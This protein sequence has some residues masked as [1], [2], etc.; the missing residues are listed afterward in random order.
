MS[1]QENQHL[2]GPAHPAPDSGSREC[3]HEAGISGDETTGDAGP[4]SFPLPVEVSPLE[5]QRAA[6]TDRRA[7]FRRHW[8]FLGPELGEAP[9]PPDLGSS[10]NVRAGSVGQHGPPAAIEHD[11]DASTELDPSL[12]SEECHAKFNGGDTK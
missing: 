5:V 1:Q 9:V 2:R 10:G 7:P 11:A 4:T 8:R 12:V 6:G 3:D